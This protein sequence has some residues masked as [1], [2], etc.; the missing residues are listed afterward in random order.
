MTTK[1][2]STP[3][4]RAGIDWGSSTFRAYLFDDNKELLESLELP[5]GI[6]YCEQGRFEETLFDSIG[7]W[8]QPGDQ[9]VLSGM[10]TSRNGWIE[11]NY[12]PCPANLQQLILHATARTFRRVN[13]LF[14]PGVSQQ[15]PPDIL[16]GEELQLLG[17]QTDKQNYSAVIPGTHSKWADIRNQ[18]IQSFRSIAIGELYDVL[19]NHSLIGAFANDEEWNQEIF[20]EAAESGYRSNTILSDLFLCRSAVILDSLP[21]QYTSSYLSG[22]LI[23]REIREGI[24]LISHRDQIIVIASANLGQK[25]LSIFEHLGITITLAHSQSAVQGYQLLMKHHE[26]RT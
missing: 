8:L 24:E 6:K 15:R 17:V 13:C 22:L 23:G 7:H 10:I 18:A 3:L 19:I 1:T 5:L 2:L 14:L 11:S 16:R 26:T 21:P 4:F 25:Y 20:L 9:V 12:L